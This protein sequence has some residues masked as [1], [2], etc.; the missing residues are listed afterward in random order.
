MKKYGIIIFLLLL[1]FGIV[2]IGV[3]QTQSFSKQTSA[4]KTSELETTVKAE[5]D[6]NEPIQFDKLESVDRL[7]I[8]GS[9]LA[10]E[11]GFSVSSSLWVVEEEIIE[12]EIE[13]EL[14]ESEEITEDE[15]DESSVYTESS[16]SAYTPKKK[17]NSSTTN[18]SSSSSSTIKKP[19][20]KP[21]ESEESI[22]SSKPKESSES[23]TPDVPVK[24]EDTIKD[25]EDE[26]PPESDLPTNEGDPLPPINGDQTGSEKPNE[27]KNSEEVTE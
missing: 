13:E 15:E 1:F 7:K 5:S 4:A 3:N 22:E 23:N 19:A 2:Y 26:I 24:D 6:T 27:E 20:P 12:E 21:K 16:S 25:E 8:R 18:S 9:K 14:V 10:S 11:M 17:T